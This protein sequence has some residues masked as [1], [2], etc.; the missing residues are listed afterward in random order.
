MAKRDKSFQQLLT[1][2]EAITES[3]EKPDLDLDVGLR[4]FERGLELS[5]ELKKR[6]LEIEQ[7]IE[8]VKTKFEQENV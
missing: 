6:L 8:K 2:L 7:K 1:E 3:L 5:Q 4:D